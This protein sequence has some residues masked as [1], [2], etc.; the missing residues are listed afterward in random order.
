MHPSEPTLLPAMA[1]RHNRKTSRLGTILTVLATVGIWVPAAA[2]AAV[3]IKPGD[4]QV[5][6]VQSLDIF[7]V[8]SKVIEW[9]LIAA[10]VIAFLYV[11][12]GGF[13]YMTSGG[14]QTGANKGKATIFNAIIGIII[15]ALSYAL[16]RFVVGLTQ[17][18]FGN[19]PASTSNSGRIQSGTATQNGSGGIVPFTRGSSSGQQ[20][21]TQPPSQIGNNSSGT[22]GSGS[23]SNS[24]S[25]S[26]SS[27]TSSS[28]SSS[29]SSSDNNQVHIGP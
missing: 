17:G 24:S 12:Y 20:T 6:L 25:S 19:A 3:S 10:G 27:S 16:V 23:I 26:S 8:V 9:A 11:L 28:N 21:V 29:S 4:L 7:S 18:S 22:S 1:H 15:I 13:L 5:G 2:H 14:D